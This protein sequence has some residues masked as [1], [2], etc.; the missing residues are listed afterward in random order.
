M[1]RWL[2]GFAAVAVLLSPARAQDWDAGLAAFDRGAFAD[3]L[4]EIEPLAENGFAPAQHKLG[5]MYQQGAGVAPNASA[6]VLWFSKALA[7]GYLPAVQS[8]AEAY[9]K[10]LG[11]PRNPAKAVNWYKLAAE[12]G[13]TR[14][15]ITL[16][17]MYGNGQ[18][19]PQ[20]LVRA[21]M[22]SNLAA[23][24]SASEAEREMALTNRE[25]FTWLMSAEQLTTAR[26]QARAWA[27]QHG[28]N[29]PPEER[30]AEEED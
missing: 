26:G 7:Q 3:A 2:I 20:D 30:W 16:G 6:A 22:W 12:G 23:V 17:A 4:A 25:H 27:A 8:I 11:V 10:G 9:R 18:E 28:T 19:V 1:K 29:A 15:M 5:Q 24:Y 21:H 14:S 13:E